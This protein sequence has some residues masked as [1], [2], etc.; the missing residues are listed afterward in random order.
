MWVTIGCILKQGVG[1]CFSGITGRDC[2]GVVFSSMG[3]YT[4]SIYWFWC[5]AEVWV[6]AVFLAII[7]LG[8]QAPGKVFLNAVEVVAY[9]HGSGA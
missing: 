9:Y 5:L 1:T 6:V 2:A 8:S 3:L 7:V 4:D